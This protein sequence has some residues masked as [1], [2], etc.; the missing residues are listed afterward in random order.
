MFMPEL[1]D[2]AIVKSGSNPV[3]GSW[4]YCAELKKRD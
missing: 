3:W 4:Q 1:R 2:I